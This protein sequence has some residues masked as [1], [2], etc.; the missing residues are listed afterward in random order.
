VD[1]QGRF[2]P[3][4]VRKQSVQRKYTA[5]Q[6]EQFFALFDRVKS[7]TVAA[8]EL[9]LNPNTCA[10]WVRKAGLKG[11]GKPGTG[12][13]PGREEFFRLRKA[14]VSRRKAAVA[15]GIHLRTAQEWG[16]GIRKSGGRRI[17]PDGRVV[18]YNVV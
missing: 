7:T 13:H 12:P 17:Y 18:D 8:G 3:G 9:G 6:K 2:D 14:G 1:P 11:Q 10:A 16:Q 4:K 15:V 5:R